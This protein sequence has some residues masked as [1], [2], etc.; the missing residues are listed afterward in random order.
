MQRL[1]HILYIHKASL[2][3]VLFKFLESTVTMQRLYHIHYSHMASL[4]YVLINVFGDDCGKKLLMIE[5]IGLR[6][7]S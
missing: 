6:S 3:C 1:F 4:H 2:K 5:D 7:K